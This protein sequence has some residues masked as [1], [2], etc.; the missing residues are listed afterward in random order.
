MPVGAETFS[1]SGWGSEI[2]QEL[3]ILSDKVIQPL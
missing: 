3:K 2:F 1:K